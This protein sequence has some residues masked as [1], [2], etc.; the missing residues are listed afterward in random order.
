MIVADTSGIVALLNA[1]DQHHLD[2]L[3]AFEAHGEQWLIPWATLPEVDYLVSKY[4]GH[5]VALSFLDDIARGVFHVEGYR[6]ED[7][8]TALKLQ[9]KY[10]A[11]ELGL[12]DTV[13][14]A[15]S[16]RFSA[17]AIVTLDER[18]FRAVS[19]GRRPPKLL[20]FDA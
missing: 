13:V 12:V 6:E 8:A 7:M 4:L 9:R 2:V 20:P 17:S 15:V 16:I 3:G 18:H 14:M 11:L 10:R 5:Q 19:L 1:D